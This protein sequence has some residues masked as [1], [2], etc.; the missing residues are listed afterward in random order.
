MAQQECEGAQ[1][2]KRP[3]HGKTALVTGA[4]GGL[5]K[6]IVRGLAEAGATVKVAC[7]SEDKATAVVNE[8]AH[9][10]H[11]ERAPETLD[12]GKQASID[13]FV[14]TYQESGAPL[15][16]LVCNAGLNTGG[17]K[18]KG[19][20]SD[21]IAAPLPM[22]NFLGHFLLVT[23]LEPVL[24]RSA[25]ARVVSVSSIMHRFGTIANADA[26]LDSNSY[27][28]TKLAQVAHMRRLQKRLY[29]KG[30]TATAVDPG[31]VRSGVWHGTPLEK[32]VGGLLRDAI[33]VSCEYGAGAAIYACQAPDS[34]FHSGAPFFTRE[35]ACT[36]QSMLEHMPK[37][38]NSSG[39]L[40]Y[41]KLAA[42]GFLGLSLLVW[43]KLKA[44]G[45]LDSP[46][47]SVR[48]NP[49]ALDDSLCESLCQ[50]SA[51]RCGLNPRTV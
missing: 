14:Q 2:R 28:A 8:I 19:S 43:D 15:H 34:Y 40:R 18:L 4:S 10:G 6:A 17:N 29:H 7:R 21:S 51:L 31:G 1:Q 36:S 3:L 41:P 20:N 33:F 30:V 27:A 13:S 24:V 42:Y 11:V 26:F 25:P 23:K 22:Q 9:A 47:V 12:L 45:S 37:V 16:L 32:G 46:V 5:G 39:M 38:M 49:E 48:P 44:L 50:T 35:G